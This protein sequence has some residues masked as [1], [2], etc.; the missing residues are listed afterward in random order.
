VA[1]IYPPGWPGGT[2]PERCPQT[3]PLT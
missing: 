2:E 1:G 3:W